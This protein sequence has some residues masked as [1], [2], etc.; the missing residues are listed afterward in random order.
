MYWRGSTGRVLS[1]IYI[2]EYYLK[3]AISNTYFLNLFYK[4]N[5]WKEIKKTTTNEDV[6]VIIKIIYLICRVDRSAIDVLVSNIAVLI[7]K[8]ATL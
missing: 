6:V 5:K 8:L 1:L 4:I 7:K 2:E 3:D